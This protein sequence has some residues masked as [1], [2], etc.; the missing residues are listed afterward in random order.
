MLRSGAGRRRRKVIAWS[1]RRRATLT[2][3]FFFDEPDDLGVVFSCSI[4]DSS[5]T[6]RITILEARC[7]REVE[8]SKLFQI[9]RLSGLWRETEKR[10]S[11]QS[12]EKRVTV[13]SYKNNSS[14]S[15]DFWIRCFSSFEKD[16]QIEFAENTREDEFFTDDSQLSR[17]SSAF[18]WSPR[19]HSTHCTLSVG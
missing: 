2:A 8:A 9:A 6:S 12:G 10:D 16:S 3:S 18:D 14:S 4:V 1:R 5:F 13:H 7:V 17:E 11:W 19:V 15:V